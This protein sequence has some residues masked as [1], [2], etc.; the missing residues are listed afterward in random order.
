MNSTDRPD[1]TTVSV[2]LPV[3]REGRG[4]ATTLTRILEQ[5]YPAIVE[6]LVVDGMSDDATREVVGEFSARDPRFKLLDNPG[7]IVP[8][9]MNVGIRAATGAIIVRVDGHTRI[10]PDYVRR[11]VAALRASSASCAGGRMDAVGV[12]FIGRVVAA[13]TSGPFGVGNSHFHYSEE[14]RFTE[15]VYLGAWPRATLLRV[16]GFDEEMVRDQDDELNYRLRKLGGTV[17]L[18]PAIR[19]EYTP[20][21]SLLKLWSQYRQYG[22]WKIRVF[23][24]HPTML[25]LRHF[26]PAAFV[27][28]ALTGIV[29]AVAVPWGRWLLAAGAALYLAGAVAAALATPTRWAERA[30]MPLVFLTIHAAYGAGFLAGLVRFFPLWFKTPS[31]PDAEPKLASGHE[32]ERP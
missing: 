15:S 19:S 6:V 13:A 28:A 29:L 23:Q 27:L 4:F 24:K 25:R 22:F 30:A 18:D 11:C 14:P 10:G 16:G 1:E 12:T 3:R 17:W 32:E 20:R 21:G 31:G 26:V 2:V 7:L 5:D 8:T 9:A